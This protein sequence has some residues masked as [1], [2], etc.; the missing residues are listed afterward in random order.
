MNTNKG[1]IAART[2]A[3]DGTGHQFLADAGFAQDQHGGVRMGDLFHLGE[4][5]YDARHFLPDK[6]LVMNAFQIFVLVILFFHLLFFVH[7]LQ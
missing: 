3:V 7:R 1:L 5:L 6:I 2:A 4:N